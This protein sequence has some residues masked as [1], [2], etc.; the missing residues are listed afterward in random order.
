MSEE[1]FLLVILGSK[2][3]CFFAFLFHGDGLSINSCKHK[4]RDCDAKLTKHGPCLQGVQNGVRK[5]KIIFKLL[6]CE[7]IRH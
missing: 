5:I 3:F 1:G 4:A 7:D 6:Y 2:P